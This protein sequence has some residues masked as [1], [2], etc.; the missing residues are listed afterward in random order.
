MFKIYACS[1]VQ[2][3]N[4]FRYAYGLWTLF[5]RPCLFFAGNLIGKMKGWAPNEKKGNS[6]LHQGDIL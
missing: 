6:F 3:V 4:N 1:A 5:P 2:V